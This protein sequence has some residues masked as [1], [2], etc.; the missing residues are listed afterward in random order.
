MNPTIRDTI[1]STVSSSHS[2]NSLQAVPPAQLSRLTNQIQGSNALSTSQDSVIERT[3]NLL[4]LMG[5]NNAMR[6]SLLQKRLF[7]RSQS[8]LLQSSLQLKLFNLQMECLNSGELSTNQEMQFQEAQ[9]LVLSLNEETQLQEA[10]LFPGSTLPP[11][12]EPEEVVN[13]G[14]PERSYFCRECHKSF[15][16]LS[17]WKRHRF[18]HSASKPFRCPFPQCIRQYAR[19]ANLKNHLRSKHNLTI[20]PKRVRPGQAI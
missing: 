15:K 4:K 8:L 1:L 5:E 10:E 20:R 19:T 7:D 14:D 17:N 18:V 12:N 2:L 9:K 3:I 11:S 6:L 13:T 16:Y